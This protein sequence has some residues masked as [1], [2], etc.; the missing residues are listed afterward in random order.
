MGGSLFGKIHCF[1]SAIHFCGD[2]AL[3]L[4]PLF[5]SFMRPCTPHYVLTSEEAII[6]GSH[7]YAS[8][9]LKASCCGAVHALLADNMITNTSHPELLPQLASFNFWFNLLQYQLPRHPGECPS[10]SLADIPLIH[11]PWW[12]WQLAYFYTPIVA[13]GI[14]LAVSRSFGEPWITGH[15]SSPPGPSTMGVKRRPTVTNRRPTV[16]KR[17]PTVTKT[18]QHRTCARIGKTSSPSAPITSTL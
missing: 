16:T 2:N 12:S 17:R 18:K 5:P 15:I 6:S 7:F 8:A 9:T 3:G 13:C 11:V 10:I 1:V 14:S 4:T